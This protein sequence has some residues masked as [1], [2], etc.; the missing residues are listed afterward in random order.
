VVKREQ[1]KIKNIQ[2]YQG[3]LDQLYKFK[4]VKFTALDP[5]GRQH[6]ILRVNSNE[7]KR[8]KDLLYGR[9]FIRKL[10]KCPYI[11]HRL[12]FMSKQDRANLAYMLRKM[13]RK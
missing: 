12:V 9:P 6:Y 3:L 8:L 7:K 2:K 11:G 13:R 5:T 1:Q 10:V 4:R